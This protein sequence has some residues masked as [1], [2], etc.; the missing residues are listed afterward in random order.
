MNRIAVLLAAAVSIAFSGSSPQREPLSCAVTGF[1]NEVSND[2]WQDARVGMGVRAMLS[3]S[4]Y[5]TGLFSLIE[6][7]DEVR[8][9]LLPVIKDVW[10]KKK[11]KK[12]LEKAADLLKKQGARFIAGGRIY[13]FGK[14]RTRASVGPVHFASD[15]VVIKIEVVIEDTE[16][17]KK[18]KAIGT[19]TAKTSAKTVLFTFHGDRLDAD[20]S[21][22]A[23]ATKKAID[24]AVKELAA[25]VQ[26]KYP[27]R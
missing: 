22:V 8:T 2:E 6:E 27:S 13:Y 15:E 12:E 18:L 26:K 24:E 11:G 7:K 23:T 14:P 9:A 1:L 5:E 20:K 19:G 25:K 17:R 16:K 4:L 10:M 3:E 21:M